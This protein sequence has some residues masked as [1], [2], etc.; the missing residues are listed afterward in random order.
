MRLVA[1]GATPIPR[2]VLVKDLTT[3]DGYAFEAARP[4]FLAAGDRIAFEDGGLVVVR[5]GGQRLSTCGEWS[6]RCGPG[7]PAMRDPKGTA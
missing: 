3:D 1:D 2:S 5:A 7:S 4:L 6:T